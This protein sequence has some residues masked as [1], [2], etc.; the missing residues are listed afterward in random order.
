MGAV[1]GWVV[2]HDGETIKTGFKHDGEAMRWLHDQHPY[3]VDH[4]VRHEG[5]DVVLVRD[6]KVEYSFKQEQFKERKGRRMGATSGNAQ[7]KKGDRVRIPEWIGGET[8]TIERYDETA[9]AYTV[10]FDD[11]TTDTYHS[12]YLSPEEE[13]LLGE[14][15]AKSKRRASS[16]KVDLENL[17]GRIN[18]EIS[19][20]QGEGDKE[21]YV[22]LLA[23]ARR[24][25]RAQVEGRPKPRGIDIDG[26]IEDIDYI[27]DGQ[28]DPMGQ[29]L[30]E[31][32][33][34]FEIP[35]HSLGEWKEIWPEGRY[36][37]LSTDRM[38]RQ[39][40][41]RTPKGNY[42]FFMHP[43]FD[44]II[45]ADVPGGNAQIAYLLNLAEKQGRSQYEEIA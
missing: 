38:N 17:I 20:L 10:V 27:R 41:L 30:M 9:D 5:Y 14:M 34:A 13:P 45:E 26:L 12:Q 4:A 36:S 31:I 19:E 2:T 6:G 25:L 35:K 21:A 24:V 37:L 40:S 28:M 1:E 39:L 33:E 8:V 3:S 16:R 7:Y 44:G 23:S 42:R 18:G 32:I 15:G 43:Y 11:G 22:D 29:F